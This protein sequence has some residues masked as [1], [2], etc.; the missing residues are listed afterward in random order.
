MTIREAF[1]NP[2]GSLRIFLQDR[3]ASEHVIYER[4]KEITALGMRRKLIAKKIA[5]QRDKRWI[6]LG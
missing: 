3:S 6:D 5:K 2:S 4:R 1:G